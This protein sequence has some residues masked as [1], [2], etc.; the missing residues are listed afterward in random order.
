MR[1]HRRGEGWYRATIGL[2]RVLLRGLDLTVRAEGLER[3]P[4]SGP[5]L[6]ASNHV[7]F[8]DFVFV[9]EAALRRGRYVRFLC[10]YDMWHQP[11]VGRAL[12]G[13]RHVPVDRAA[14][15]GAYLAA[16]RLLGEGEAVCAF[17]EAGISHSYTVR[18]LMPGVAALARE[19]GIPVVP[20]AVW[21][22]QRLW[23][24][25]RSVDE[26]QT[27]PQLSRGRLV[28]VRFG[29]AIPVAA[30]ADLGSVTTV[31]GHRV[32]QMLEGLQELP[33]HRPRPGERA[34]WY[35]AHLGGTA[36]T[37]EQAVPLDVVPRTAVR[38]TWGPQPQPAGAP[39]LVEDSGTARRAGAPPTSTGEASPD[40][41]AR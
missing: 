27:R 7:S 36:P 16:R 34:R 26:A 19:T 20:V 17:P 10:R 8:P 2:G 12:D 11:V 23:P 5:V 18:S 30:D 39:G 38:P 9:G 21:G 41:A 29:E 15:A 6:L 25:R 40:T 31:L 28:D 4:A 37:R 24:M 3:L 13:M 32:T 35:P 14:P 1:R 22:S 33:E